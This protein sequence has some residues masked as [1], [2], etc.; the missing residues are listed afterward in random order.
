MHS[1]THAQI[2][3]AWSWIN[4]LTDSE[5]AEGATEV[6]KEKP[7]VSLSDSEAFDTDLENEGNYGIME[8]ALT[9]ILP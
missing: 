7:K 1:W 3:H 2:R 8:F 5:F 4:W 9:I 6:E